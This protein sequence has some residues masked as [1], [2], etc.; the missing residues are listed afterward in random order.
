[1]LVQEFLEQSARRF[2]G[3]TAII[4]GSERLTWQ[5]IDDRANRLAHALRD[6]GVAS[7]DRVVV[8]LDNSPETVISIFGILKADAVFSIVNPTIKEDKLSY[9]LNNCRAAA[10]ITNGIKWQTAQ[11]AAAEAPLLRTVFLADTGAAARAD[12]GAEPGGASHQ[13][14]VPWI[15]AL[16]AQ[17]AGAP[18]R[19]TSDIDLASLSYTAGT[20]GNPKGVMMTHQ[21]MVAASTSITT[22]LRNS[23]QDI[24]LSVLPLSFDYGLYQI[25]MSAQFGGTVV[26]EKA[27]LYPYAVINTLKRERVTGFPHVPTI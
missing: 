10:L 24:I 6:S 9:I 18:P 27:F 8:V 13:R 25:I 2:P 3:K 17:P 4:A 7:G 19:K 11:T 22:Y 16:S 5:E 23:D 21:N 26:L 14:L 1:M 20:T 12:G 15:D